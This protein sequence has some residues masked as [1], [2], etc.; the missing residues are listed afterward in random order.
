MTSYLRKQGN[1]SCPKTKHTE[2]THSAKQHY[3]FWAQR[4]QRTYRH[5]VGNVKLKETAKGKK[6]LE[7]NE[8]KRQQE[9][10]QTA[11]ISKAMPRKMFATVGSE[12]HAILVYKL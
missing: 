7:F 4:L 9:P 8:K 5:V 3:F 11:A 1:S 12:K 6:Y 10:N 2:S